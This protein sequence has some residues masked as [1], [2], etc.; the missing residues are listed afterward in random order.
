[1]F[2]VEEEPVTPI[3]KRKKKS[4]L[5]HGSVKVQRTLETT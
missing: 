4:Q 3:Y 5:S 2:S 1:M